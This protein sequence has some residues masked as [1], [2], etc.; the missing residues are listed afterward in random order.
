M[1]LVIERYRHPGTGGIAESL[2]QLLA[3]GSQ[4]QS[5]SGVADHRVL[6]AVIEYCPRCMARARMRVAP[7]SS[8]L[9]REEL[10]PEDA[11]PAGDQLSVATGGQR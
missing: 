2:F 4:H 9:P 11:R 10:Y 8:T 7:C 5:E 1:S 3:M 6:P